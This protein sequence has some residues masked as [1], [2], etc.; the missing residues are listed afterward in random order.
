MGIQVGI[1]PDSWGAWYPEDDHQTPWQRC[2]DEMKQAGYEGIELGPWGYFPQDYK[3]L[4]DELY[5]RDLKLV[6][7]TFSVDFSDDAAVENAKIVLEKIVRLLSRFKDARYMVLLVEMLSDRITGE[8]LRPEENTDKSAKIIKNVQKI[9]DYCRQ[10]STTIIPVLHPYIN[11]DICTEEEIDQILQ[12]TDIDLCM[13]VMHLIAGG[14]DPIDFY[15]KHYDRIAYIHLMECHRDVMQK[16]KE[17]NWSFA[18]A[19][20]EGLV[21]EPGQGETDFPKLFRLLEEKNFSGWITVEH[22]MYPI[23]DFNAPLR[24]ASNTRKYLKTLNV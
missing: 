18:K 16:M 7:G 2:M 6:A 13:D 4:R 9:A 23:R 12:N 24:V 8:K 15:Q 19:I 1:A 10:I 20:A 22:D 14:V 11:S 17:N 3:T 5:K 21:C